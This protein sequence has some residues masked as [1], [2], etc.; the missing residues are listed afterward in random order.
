MRCPI[1]RRLNS[2][3]ASATIP[4]SVL[5]VTKNEERRLRACLSALYA[6]D[7]VIVIDSS[8]TDRTV[9]IAREYGVQS[10]EFSWNGAYPKKRGWVLEH[11]QTRHD[12]ILFLDA[13]E[14]MT[15]AVQAEIEAIF[16]NGAPENI[17][18]YFVPARYIWLGRALRFGL[19]N[20][21]LCLFN[22]RQLEFPVVDDLDAPGMGEIEGHYQPVLKRSC[23]GAMIGGLRASLL[24]DACASLDDWEARHERYARW[25]VYMNAHKAWPDEDQG[26]RRVMKYI[27]RA[28]PLRGVFAFL[29]SYIL[30]LGVLDGAAGFDFARSRYRYYAMIERL[31]KAR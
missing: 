11:V 13:D 2:L 3:M 5:I 17:A 27:F 22:R 15:P 14:L 18:G 4:V 10:V 8:S 25:E 23:R 28:L 16:A 7:E 6:F 30:K 9:D 29:H 26:L 12:W 31:G 20:S 19:K 1:V 21:K 24:H